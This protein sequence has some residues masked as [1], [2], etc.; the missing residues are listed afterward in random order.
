MSEAIIDLKEFLERVQDDRDLLVELL[1]IYQEDFTE[2]RKNLEVGVQK[3]DFDQIKSVAHSLKGS[4]GN[5]SAKP[6]HACFLKIEQLAKSSDAN[7][8]LEVLGQIDK[9]FVELQAYVV[10]LKAELKK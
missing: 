9:H 3:K 7:G 8:M 2:K 5:I 6:L 1:D 4:S 10:Q